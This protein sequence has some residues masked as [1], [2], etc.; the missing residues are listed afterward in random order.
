MCI[1]P[2]GFSQPNFYVNGSTCNAKYGINIKYCNG[3][4]ADTPISCYYT[5]TWDFKKGL[6]FRI[7]T[8]TEMNIRFCI[9]KKKNK[10]EKRGLDFRRIIL[11]AR[12]KRVFCI[13][14]YI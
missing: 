10:V 4:N 7:E 1:V 12:H 14:I 11:L 5:P 3:F 2:S 13:G 9:K 6:Q 8:K